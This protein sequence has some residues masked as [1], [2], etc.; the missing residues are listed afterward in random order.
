[1]PIQENII[2]SLEE[3]KNQVVRV[4]GVLKANNLR[5]Q[6]QVDD[7]T[8]QL[9]EKN[10]EIEVLESKFQSLKLTK[11]LTPSPESVR[12]VKFQVNRM[13]REIDKCIALLNK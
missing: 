13:V 1:M 4:V 6:K 3:K 11:I 5:L 10:K 2:S 8:G 9:H 12:K 7:L